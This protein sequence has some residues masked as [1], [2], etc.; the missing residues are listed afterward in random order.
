M[1]AL[2]RSAIAASLI[3]VSGGLASLSAL[4][5][6]SAIAVGVAAPRAVASTALSSTP[7][8][9]TQAAYDGN[10]DDWD[11]NEPGLSPSTV[12][13]A[14]FGQIWRTFVGGAIYAQPLVY[15]GNVIVN[16]ELAR[17]YAL[18][19]QTG[20]VVWRR[21]FGT[22]FQAKATS[23]SSLVPWLGST[24]TGV[25]DPSTGIYYVTTRLAEGGQAL[26]DSHWFL[27]AVS[28]RTGAE[29]PGFP[30]ELAGTPVNTPGVPFNEDNEEQRPALL[31]LGGVVYI[32]FASDCDHT[33]YRGIIIGVNATTGA[34][35]T[36]WSDESG[37]GTGDNSQG[38]IWLSGA[39]IVSIAPGQMILTTGNG[40][41]P[42][43]ARSNAPPS[44]LSESVVELNVGADGSLTPT[45]FFA[46]HNSP[47][48]D[49][50]DFEIGSAGPVALPRPYFG[51]TS[52]PQL[53]V[54]DGKVGTIYLLNAADLGGYRQGPNGGD[55]VVQE[56]GPYPA[57]LGHPAAYGGQG[58]W[59]YYAENSAR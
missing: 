58:G 24:S 30:V 25:I 41:S 21:A 48:L 4:G 42:T 31:L 19:A 59:V 51:T 46:P 7:G 17:A 44:T 57:V 3:V 56:L 13:S 16:T 14:S 45:Q 1:R 9:M 2:R 33:P 47:T 11:Q 28:A 8:D 35:S 32:A 26:A 20:K 23:C 53:I 36:M 34:I 18:N 49:E 37:V 38:G 12:Q 40:V 27:Q 10:R 50:F 29:E 15:G 6:S 55:Q 52:I 39:G 22:P 5:G 43:P 54:Q